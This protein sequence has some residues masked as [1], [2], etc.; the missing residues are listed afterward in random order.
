MVSIKD[1]ESPGIGLNCDLDR[2]FGGM[3]Q[4]E[5]EHL[6]VG[7]IR[8]YRVSVALAETARLDW[9]TAETDTNCGPERRAELRRIHE[10]AEAD[11]RAR[12]LILNNLIDR[13]GYVPKV[14]AG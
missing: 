6:T 3:T 8:E 13:L 4:P 7:A 1:D 5:I 11:H 10:H 9:A 14:P 2:I 12:Q